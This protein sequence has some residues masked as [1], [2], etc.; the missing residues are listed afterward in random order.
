MP[1]FDPGSATVKVS[2]RGEETEKKRGKQCRAPGKRE[3][4]QVNVDGTQIEQILRAGS[5][6][7]IR[8][9]KRQRHADSPTDQSEQRAL[10]EQL[11]RYSPA[12][13][14]NRRSNR[15]LL[16]ASRGTS[17]QEARHVRARNQ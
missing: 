15:H 13:C 10:R 4:A 2:K 5:K 3:N 16:F 7:S 1:Y 12:A 14:A 6:Q 9:P 8:S 17:Q 11:P